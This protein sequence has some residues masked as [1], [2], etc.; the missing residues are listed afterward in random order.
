MHART[1]VDSHAAGGLVVGGLRGVQPL[2]VNTQYSIQI[3]VGININIGIDRY[4]PNAQATLTQCIAYLTQITLKYKTLCMY[5]HINTACA[6]NEARVS[7]SRIPTPTLPLPHTPK[8][9]NHASS[10]HASP[11][12]ALRYSPLCLHKSLCLVGPAIV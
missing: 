12:A 6:S 5:A 7:T 4:S 3:D 1:G 10:S 2:R 9:A 8:S 11:A